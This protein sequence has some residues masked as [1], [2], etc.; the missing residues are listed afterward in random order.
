[1]EVQSGDPP[2]DP[3]PACSVPE[4]VNVFLL[5]FNRVVN[6]AHV[7]RRY[8]AFTTFLPASM[9]VCVCTSMGYPVKVRKLQ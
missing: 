8:I 6:V 3:C 9:A 7:H 1:M 4:N 5:V 2:E